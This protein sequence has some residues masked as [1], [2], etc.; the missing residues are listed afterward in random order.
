[1]KLL[2]LALA[3]ALSLSACFPCNAQGQDDAGYESSSIG[4]NSSINA[5]PGASTLAVGL[6]SQPNIAG[7]SGLISAST[8]YALPVWTGADRNVSL[9]YLESAPGASTLAV[10]LYSQPNIAGSSG[11]ISASQ[12][13]FGVNSPNISYVGG[14][15]TLIYSGCDNASLQSPLDTATLVMASYSQPNTTDFGFRSGTG[16]VSLSKSISDLTAN[17]NVI[18]GWTLI[19]Q[20]AGAI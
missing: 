5:A 6:Y 3:L 10:G 8:A 11:L 2:V 7:S 13:F 15:V 18:V 20:T 12:V 9:Q 4:M 19:Y 14:N 1:M 16:F 17:G